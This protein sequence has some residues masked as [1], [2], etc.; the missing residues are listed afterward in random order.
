MCYLIILFDFN[1]QVKEKLDEVEQINE[2]LKNK[3]RQMNE[4]LTNK[5]RLLNEKLVTSSVYRIQKPVEK[6]TKMIKCFETFF[7]FSGEIFQK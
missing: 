2:D 7:G 1:V 4:D 6:V 3:M 5:V